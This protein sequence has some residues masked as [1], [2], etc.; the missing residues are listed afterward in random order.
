MKTCLLFV[1]VLA[2]AATN[3]IRQQRQANGCG[4][5]Y[6]NIDESLRG[7]GESVIIPCCNQHDLCY[8]TCGMPQSRCDNRFRRCLDT[9]CSRLQGNGFE[10]WIDVR[11][12]ACKLDGRVLYTIVNAVGSYAYQSA[13]RAHGCRTG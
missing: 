7:V 2:I 4:P 10:W 3:G 13:Q 6:Y 12:A 11:R 5:G 1:F 8:D 9:A